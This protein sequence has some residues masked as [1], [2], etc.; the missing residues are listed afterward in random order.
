MAPNSTVTKEKA[1]IGDLETSDNGVRPRLA[2]HAASD[3]IN[4]G[5]CTTFVQTSHQDFLAC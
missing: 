2:D 3:R 1:S 5:L 4:A